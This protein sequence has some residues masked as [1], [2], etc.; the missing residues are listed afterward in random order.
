MNSL[1]MR[2]RSGIFFIIGQAYK[3]YAGTNDNFMG[4]G[5]VYYRITCPQNAIS[6]QHVPAQYAFERVHGSHR[7]V[8]NVGSSLETYKEY[9][10]CGSRPRT[11][12][13]HF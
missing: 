12:E 10:R 1:T 5:E 7:S 13:A 6:F 4:V 8:I 2:I 9:Q 11:P 3:Q